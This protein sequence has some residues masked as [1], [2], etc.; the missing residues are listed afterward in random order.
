MTKKILAVLISLMCIMGAFTSGFSVCATSVQPKATEE[1]SVDVTLPD[2]TEDNDFEEVTPPISVTTTTQKPDIKPLRPVFSTRPSSTTSTTRKVTEAT[3]EPSN[4][5]R[6]TTTR[7]QPTNSTTT[8]PTTTEPVLPDGAF[9][10]F[11]E[12]NNGE[13]RLKRIMEKEGLVPAPNEP[14]REGYIFDGWYGDAK[15]EK[16]WSFYTD[17][18]KKGTI[19]Y[20]K[21]I[22]DGGSQ[23]YKITVKKVEGGIIEVNPSSASPDEYVV[24][25]VTPDDG[26]RLVAG[27]VTVNGVPTDV[28]SF[29]MPSK[30]VVINARFED[31]PQNDGQGEGNNIVPFVIGGVLILLAAI[32]VVIVAVARRRNDVSEAQIDENGTIIDDDDDY[33]WYD[34]TIVVEDGFKEGE[35]V[36]KNFVAEDEDESFG[37]D[38]EEDDDIK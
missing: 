35:K 13:K 8:A 26:K 1:H 7:T 22:P 12:K 16:P 32:A 20:A 25:N 30:N 3:S 34:D 23:Q 38:D 21:W 11:L 6:P 24:I 10:V 29:A 2:T 18:A 14:V 19:I 36:G 17:Y 15:F 31:I 27:S 28:L 33:D 37:I 9:Y 4:T 5:R